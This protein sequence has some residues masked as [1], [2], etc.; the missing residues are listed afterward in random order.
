MLR[1]RGDLSH[2]FQIVCKFNFKIDVIIN[3]V[4]IKAIIW[5]LK[6]IYALKLYQL[7]LFNFWE[8]SI[9]N[10]KNNKIFFL[11]DDEEDEEDEEI[12]EFEVGLD[13]VYKDH[14]DVSIDAFL[15]SL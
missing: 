4:I 7:T 5:Q 3:K 6:N 8:I 11:D 12:D 15:V 14:L 13:A 10:Q 9:L 2:I 1:G